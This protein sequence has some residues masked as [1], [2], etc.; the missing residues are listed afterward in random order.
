MVEDGGDGVLGGACR[1]GCGGGE[2]KEARGGVEAGTCH[3]GGVC[4][5][6]AGVYL[7]WARM[8]ERRT[9]S[10]SMSSGLAL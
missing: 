6:V 7:E 9:A 8:V 10:S 1:G 5:Y 3:G 2:G 4:A